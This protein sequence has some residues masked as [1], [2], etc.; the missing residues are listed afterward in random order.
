MYCIRVG[1]FDM[2]II[3]LKHFVFNQITSSFDGQKH[4]KQQKDKITINLAIY[5]GHKSKLC[6]H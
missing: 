5:N 4:F 1:V 2:I 3:T 6:R